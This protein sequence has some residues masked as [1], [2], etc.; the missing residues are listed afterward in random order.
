[1]LLC[2]TEPFAQ[3]P[4]SVVSAVFI[5]TNCLERCWALW[6]HDHYII[7]VL[8]CWQGQIP[9]LWM[10][11]FVDKA[12]YLYCVKL[13]SLWLTNYS[14]QNDLGNTYGWF[15]VCV[16]NIYHLHYFCPCFWERVML[17]HQFCSFL[18][19]FDL[20]L[21]YVNQQKCVKK[22]RSRNLC[23]T[24][25]AFWLLAHQYGIKLH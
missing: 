9:V 1:M 6:C 24:L 23:W 16:F 13:P 10:F 22:Y 18:N 20:I 2:C 12:K 5:A 19:C 14:C 21:W 15:C 4:S 25:C 8:F 3:N 17:L 7:N 11:C